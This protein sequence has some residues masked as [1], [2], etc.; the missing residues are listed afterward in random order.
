MD[1]T[2]LKTLLRR[3]IADE[4]TLWLLDR[5]I[6]NSNEQEFVCDY[7]FGDTLF[8]PLERRKGLPIGNLTSQFLANF[9][10]NDFDHFI[11]EELGC[12]GYLRYVDDFVLF[13]NSKYIL[14]ERH[15]RLTAYL[16]TLRLK[17]NP[18]RVMLYPCTVGTAFLG[19]VIYRSHRRLRGENVRKC[20]KRLKDWEENPPENVEHRIASWLGHAT[21]ADTRGLLR[22]LNLE[23]SSIE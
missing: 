14:Q 21:Q 9:Y 10:L 17:L 16:D 11:K 3:R 6:D 12:K 19:Q 13:G 20:R 18:A 5:I 8:S 22:A 7:Y 15:Y 2:I 4:R 23:L 1:H